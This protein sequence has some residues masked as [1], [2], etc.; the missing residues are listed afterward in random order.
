MTA[1]APPGA[2]PIWGD[3]WADVRVLWPID[4]SVAFLNHGS[5][6]ATPIPVLEAQRGWR[7]AMEAQPV[8]FLWRRLPSLLEDARVACAA[9]LGTDPDGFAFVPNA[10]AGVATVLAS[11]RLAPGEHILI[12][13]HAYPAIRNAAAR[14]C[15]EAGTEPAVVR[16]PLPLPDPAGIVERFAAGVTA[17][18]RL[19]IVDQVTSPTAS[20]FPVTEV[21]SACHD[22]GALVLVDGAHAPGMLAAPVDALG[23]D[24]WTGNFH[25]WVCAPKGSG[26]LVVGA[27]HRDRVH[28]LVASHGMEQGFR[29]EF[30]WTGTKDDTASLSVPAAVAF[31]AGL[32]WDRVRRHN[33]ELVAYGR[34]VVSQAL[35]TEPPVPPSAFGSM[36]LVALPDGAAG[37]LEE[38]AALGTALY[39]KERIEVPFVAWNGRGH[40]RLSA[41]VY[42]APGDYDRLAEALPRLL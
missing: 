42:N 7:D 6:G 12:S 41:Q 16:I 24:F 31:M 14:A 21:T 30:D 29:A 9:F 1:E 23:A 33:H 8:D 36:A 27:E 39:E 4:P 37:T 15:A 17:R 11:M 25:K 38:A 32:G 20:L 3:D 13:D 18:T 19:V 22:R 40:I 10:T 5:F 28:P 34:R 26:G 2:N 35:G